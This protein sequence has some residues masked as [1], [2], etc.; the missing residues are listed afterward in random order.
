M[1]AISR[2]GK[3][4][5]Q[6]AQSSTEKE[7]ED[8]REPDHGYDIHTEPETSIGRM[9]ILDNLPQPSHSYLTRLAARQQK[10]QQQEEQR[11]ENREDRGVQVDNLEEASEP[12]T[13]DLEDIAHYG[14]IFNEDEENRP[15][16]LG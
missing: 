4:V 6:E 7:R 3:T 8:Q 11:E 9:K 10:L 15:L 13:E 12:S 1:S 2:H 5:D 16:D 14:G